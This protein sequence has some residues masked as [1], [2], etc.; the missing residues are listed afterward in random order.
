MISCT[1]KRYDWSSGYPRAIP[2]PVRRFMKMSR[3][4]RLVLDTIVFGWSIGGIV[5]ALLLVFGSGCVAGPPMTVSI[6]SKFSAHPA[7]IAAFNDARDQYCEKLG[8]CFSFVTDG[9]VHIARR[10]GMPSLGEDETRDAG[11][12]H[13][14]PNLTFRSAQLW[15]DGDFM[16]EFPEMAWVVIAH[17][18]GHAYGLEHSSDPACVM[19][20]DHESA[21]FQLDCEGT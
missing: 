3:N 11:M 20:P 19:Y 9:A 1:P 13:H 21:M 6:D 5:I 18:L 4:T 2:P 17:E 8:W 7:E 16:A 15:V 10:E 14:I 12:T